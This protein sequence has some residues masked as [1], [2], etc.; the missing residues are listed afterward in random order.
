MILAQGRTQGAHDITDAKL[1]SRD[2]IGVTL[3]DRN[4]PRL[5][6]RRPRQV[7]RVED[8]SFVEERGFGAVYILSDMFP[9]GGQ[10]P[11]NLGQNAPAKPDGSPPIVVNRE[12]QPPPKPLDHHTF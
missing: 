2:H 7:G 6:A 5:T 8:R 12:H 10:R 11:F 1:M 4:P 3:D 9:K